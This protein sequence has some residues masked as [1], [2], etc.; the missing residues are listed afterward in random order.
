MYVENY[1]YTEEDIKKLLKENCEIMD[2]LNDTLLENVKL[3]K[4]N[5]GNDR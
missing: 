4:G 5:E 3:R 2:K 1:N